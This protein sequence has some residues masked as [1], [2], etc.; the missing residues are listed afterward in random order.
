M[1]YVS[2]PLLLPVLFLSTCSLLILSSIGG[3]PFL[4]QSIWIMVGCGFL[5]VFSFFNW[6]PFMNYQWFVGGI[7]AMAVLLL[8]VTY[9]LA[10]TIRGVRAWIVFGSFFIQTSEF[11]KAGLIFV[12]AYFFGKYHFSIGQVRTIFFSFLLVALPI[13]LVLIQPDLGSAIVL[14]GLWFSLLVLSGLR[15]RHFLTFIAIFLLVGFLSWNYFLASYQKER[16]I[17][18]FNPTHDQ[19]GVNYN[20]IQSKIAIGSAGLWGKGYGQGTQ[21]QLGFL[22]QA[23]ADFVLAAFIE[24]WGVVGGFLVIAAFL[25]LIFTILK[26]G[27]LA[28][29]NFE[30]FICLGTATVMSFHFVINTASVIGFFP[31]V[32]IPF[33]FLSYGGSSLLT[34]FFLLSIVYSIDRHR[35]Q[36]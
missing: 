7:Y 8:I 1:K 33:P 30:K 6:R 21:T 32:G 29:A 34:N 2:L 15:L 9:F 3:R 24:E 25:Y 18:V 12:F 31:V 4:F 20:L 23:N 11:M 27:I 10:P 13:G 36:F 14:G 28:E 19:L 22:P 16:I 26:I 35:Y 5:F 17:G